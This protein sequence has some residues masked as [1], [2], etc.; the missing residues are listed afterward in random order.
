MGILKT[1]LFI[2]LFYYG[3]KI[4]SRLFAPMIMRYFSKKVQEKFGAQF[5]D[6]AN[7]QKQQKQQTKEKEGEITIDKMP[8]NSTSNKNVGEYV[9]YE[10]VD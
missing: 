8:Q 5:K 6:F 3:Y 9:D 2:L 4:V 10:E 7:Q 1:I